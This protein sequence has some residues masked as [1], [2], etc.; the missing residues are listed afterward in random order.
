MTCA[1]ATELAEYELGNNE[2]G[3]ETKKNLYNKKHG[4]DCSIKFDYFRSNMEIVE[5]IWYHF[6]CQRSSNAG[7]TYVLF[8]ITKVA[9][10]RPIQ[11]SA[12]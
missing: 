7:L 2:K 11:L 1:C 6:A 9:I 12:I 10:Q 4:S 3:A 5:Q 8:N